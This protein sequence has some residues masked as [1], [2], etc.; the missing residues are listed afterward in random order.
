MSIQSS[1]VSPIPKNYT[2]YLPKKCRHT[3]LVNIDLDSIKNILPKH[4]DDLVQ[5]MK[6]GANDDWVFV[7][8]Y[9]NGF[10]FFDYKK[11]ADLAKK[12]VGF[13]IQFG[14]IVIADIEQP[15][16]AH[17]TEEIHKPCHIF[18]Y[19]T[20]YPATYTFENAI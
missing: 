12:Q 3:A 10:V 14:K 18:K 13:P 8:I 20:D 2:L 11:I 19:Y 5:K 1:K 17:Y 15:Q 4:Y 16:I 9:K 7:T 6:T